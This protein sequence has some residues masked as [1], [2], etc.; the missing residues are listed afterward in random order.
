MK[1]TFTLF[2]AVAAPV[3]VALV[4]AGCGGSTY[5]S[6]PSGPAAD[7]SGAARL[8]V[9]GS[10]LGRIVVDNSSGLTLYLFEK[11]ENGR[12][13]CSGQCATYWPPLLTNAGPTARVGL[14]QMLLGTTRRADGSEQVTYAGHPLY[15]Y[16]GDSKPGQTNGEG[17]QDFGAEWD[18]LSPTGKQVESDD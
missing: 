13:A 4:I 9:A 6:N 10:P 5:G 15:R 16:I 3:A 2:L 7:A 8:A 12:S 11:D 1:R 18:A 14:T 17:L